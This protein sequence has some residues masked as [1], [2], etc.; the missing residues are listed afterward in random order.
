MPAERPLALVLKT[1]NRL[2]ISAANAR[3]RA[4][5]VAAGLGLADA[6]AA[7]PGLAT[8][9]ADPNAD[10]AALVRLAAW[11]G[12][13]GPNRNVEG[14]DG[15]WV[16]ITG[17][18]HL[19]GGEDALCTDVL[20][21]GRR[22][23]VTARVAIADTPRAAH[24]LARYRTSA[25][26][27]ASLAPPGET[28]QALAPLP[29]EALDAGPAAERLLRRLGLRRIGDLVRLPRDSLE[30]RF[31]ELVDTGRTGR[32]KGAAH[33]AGSL[34]ARLDEALGRAASPRAPLLER[35]RALARAVFAEPLISADGVAA[36]LATLITELS[37]AL[38]T[39]A[40]GARR[41]ELL[42]FKVDASATSITAATGAPCRDAAHLA[43]LFRE[44]L[45]GIDAGFGIDAMTLEAL[46]PKPFEVDHRALGSRARGD[47]DEAL[48]RAIDR[49]ANRLGP[50]RVVRLEARDSHVPERAYLRRP[51]Q[52]SRP[53]SALPP[54]AAET[55][56]PRP[57]LIFERPEPIEVVAEIPD[58]PPARFTWRRVSRRVR[59][60]EGP[61]RIAPEW[62]LEL[63]GTG[64]GD[65]PDAKFFR[66]RDYFR[67]E[68][69]A[70]GRYWVFRSGL[71][72][73]AEDEGPPA[74]FLQGLYG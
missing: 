34:Q 19:F 16:D 67:I 26:H 73:E 39:R 57:I 22:A 35:P 46:D 62:W 42:V 40:A 30:R 13:Y 45:E 8:L 2:V 37:R 58:G 49:I 43:V 36:C 25:A 48:S 1:G 47:K 68:D 55:Q 64:G 27:P 18:A 23:G 5:G 31:R 29:V 6:K 28:L 56:P 65:A 10:R 60:S 52:A 38:E 70:G 15:L 53:A 74:W 61:E 21:H 4:L 44:R 7:L 69:E 14:D 3:A 9:P 59:R 11:A 66:T 41:F 33:A 54:A 32:A 71:Y 50:E 72:G 51:A 20:A 63:G 24:A 17:V 12:R